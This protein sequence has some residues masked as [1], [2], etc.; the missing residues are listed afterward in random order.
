MGCLS[1]AAFV[2]VVA[3]VGIGID[4]TIE[5][6]EELRLNQQL[7]LLC[8]A[9][10][11]AQAERFGRLALPP[12]VTV[13]RRRVAK[14]LR[15]LVRP[16]VRIQSTSVLVGSKWLFGLTARHDWPGT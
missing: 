11:P 6:I 15:G 4:H 5:H 16:G 13:V 9:E 14:R 7:D 3:P 8:D 12:A 2:L 1:V 10:S